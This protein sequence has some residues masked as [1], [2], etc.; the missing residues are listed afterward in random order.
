MTIININFNIIFLAYFFDFALIRAHKHQTWTQTIK[1]APPI[2][3]LLT[4][5]D[6][7]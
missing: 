4:F 5:V 6:D 2:S 7:S 1:Q 3:V